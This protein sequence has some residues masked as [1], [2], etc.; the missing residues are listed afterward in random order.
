MPV[1]HQ[2]YFGYTRRLRPEPKLHEFAQ[3]HFKQL[4]Y[5]SLEYFH[6]GEVYTYLP[7]RREGQRD[8]YKFCT[9]SSITASSIPF[10]FHWASPALSFVL[11]NGKG[12]FHSN[13]ISLQTTS[14]KLQLRQNFVIVGQTFGYMVCI[15]ALI[16]MH[17]MYLVTL[18]VVCL[19]GKQVSV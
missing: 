18:N 3:S 4:S 9:R 1:V 8:G 10:S 17:L 5:T 2:D 15:W 19:P 7:A 16:K 11:P 6:E 12:I 14:I 13:W